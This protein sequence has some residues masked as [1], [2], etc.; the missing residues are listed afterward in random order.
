MI[1]IWRL[2]LNAV[3]PLLP[4]GKNRI[5]KTWKEP[6]QLIIPA[7]APWL[8]SPNHFIHLAILQRPGKWPFQINII[9]SSNVCYWIWVK[10]F[11]GLRSRSLRC[12]G[13][14]FLFPLCAPWGIISCPAFWLPILMPAEIVYRLELIIYSTNP[15]MDLRNPNKSPSTFF[16]RNNPIFSNVSGLQIAKL[17]HLL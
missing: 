12:A 10:H 2:H 3:A 4:H 16:I 7:L 13:N 1:V 14:F 11:L 5:N 17:P 8:T 6:I 9:F 15:F